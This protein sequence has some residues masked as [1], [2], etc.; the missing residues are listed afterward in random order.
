VSEDLHPFSFQ[1]GIKNMP[2][3]D[4]IRNICVILHKVPAIKL[5][6]TIF[7][8]NGLKEGPAFDCRF[9]NNSEGLIEGLGSL[10]FLLCCY[11]L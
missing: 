4:E 2:E 7:L 10:F 5:I 1:L 3:V 6:A 11:L 9:P 8:S